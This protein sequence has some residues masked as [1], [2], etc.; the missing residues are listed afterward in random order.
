MKNLRYVITVLAILNIGLAAQASAAGQPSKTST[1]ST[2][3]TTPT[4]NKI[5]VGTE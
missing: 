4:V 1:V 5:F 2:G 3:T